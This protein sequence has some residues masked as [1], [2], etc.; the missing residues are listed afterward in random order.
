MSILK[1]AGVLSLV[2]CASALGFAASASAQTR[3]YVKVVVAPHATPVHAAPQAYAG[4][5]A[6]HHGE[7][8]CPQALAQARP[9]AQPHVQQYAP[10]PD[11]YAAPAAAPSS[12]AVVVYNRP[13][14]SIAD[15]Q[16]YPVQPYYGADAG[17]Y[18]EPR[19]QSRWR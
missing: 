5:H 2:A 9:H 17:Y 3:V 4:H 6:Q 13:H 8:P 19:Q 14:T 12:R 16:P 15:V 18:V 11:Y 1:K 10:A 7:A